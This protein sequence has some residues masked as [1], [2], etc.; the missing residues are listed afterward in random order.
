MSHDEQT[1]A[2]EPMNVDDA[3]GREELIDA[4]FDRNL[5]GGQQHLGPV[6][7]ALN[8]RLECAQEAE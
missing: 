6:L 3:L 8:N 1:A 2:P 4:G 5:F 7:R